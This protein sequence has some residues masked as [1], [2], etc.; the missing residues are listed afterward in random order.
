MEKALT[1][2]TNVSRKIPDNPDVFLYI[3]SIYSAMNEDAKAIDAIRKAISLK[4]DDENLYFQ[5]GVILER[6]KQFDDAVAAFRKTIEL[7]PGHSNALNYLG[8]MFADRGI[9]LEE[10][11]DLIKQALK[12]KPEDP[13]YQDSL[14]WV[15]YKM[16]RSKDAIRYL[17]KANRNLP[18]DPVVTEH[19]G[20]AYFKAGDPDK[21]REFWD[22]SLQAD[23]E[24]ETLREK[25]KKEMP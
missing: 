20:D 15:Y 14:G 21:A 16:N 5:L 22:K 17:E 23:P 18:G 12:I 2:L 19:L 13:Y 8:Y 1:L 3:A 9:N 25:L 24:N 7:N 10:A 4:S 11:E 6:Q